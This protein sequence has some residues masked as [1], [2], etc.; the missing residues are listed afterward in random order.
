MQSPGRDLEHWRTERG[1]TALALAER[2]GVSRGSLIP[3]P[4]TGG[5]LP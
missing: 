3:K 5:Q 4:S 2:A 1:F